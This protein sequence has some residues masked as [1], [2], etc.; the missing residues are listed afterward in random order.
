M[1]SLRFTWRGKMRQPFG[2]PLF[3][4]IW[5]MQP[6]KFLQKTIMVKDND[7]DAAFH[8][9][10]RLM[11][12]EGLIKTIRN[13]RYFLKPFMQR[14]QLAK[15]AAEAIINEDRERKLK[16]L[17]RKNRADAYPGQITN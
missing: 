11:E 2:M 13:T 1:P 6:G 15:E 14:N 9:L 5:A 4:G 3:H 16:F 17:T 8:I 12:R 10:N 7:V